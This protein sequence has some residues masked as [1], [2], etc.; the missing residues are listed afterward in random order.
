MKRDHLQE[1]IST[2]KIMI[3]RYRLDDQPISSSATHAGVFSGVLLRANIL[4]VFCMLAHLPIS[5]RSCWKTSEKQ[6]DS[7]INA[8]TSCNSCLRFPGYGHLGRNRYQQEP[9]KIRGPWKS[10]SCLLIHFHA[11]PT[12]PPSSTQTSHANTCCMIR[13]WSSEQH[14]VCY[15][16]LRRGNVFAHC[17]SQYD[18][19]N[20]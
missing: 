15:V 8:L 18:I 4:G 1:W 9:C 5:V 13:S 20:V 16:L 10:S 11:H 17:I 2:C 19:T 6:A 3:T 12:Y 14:V 7:M